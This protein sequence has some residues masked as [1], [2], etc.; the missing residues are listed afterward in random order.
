MKGNIHL[1]AIK[2]SLMR[3]MNR[4][5]FDRLLNAQSGFRWLR[6]KAWLTES[7]LSEAIA[8]DTS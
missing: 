6:L 5:L 1:M 7:V 8:E 3:L 4:L 2:L